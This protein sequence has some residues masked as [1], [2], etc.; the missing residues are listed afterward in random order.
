MEIHHHHHHLLCFSNIKLEMSPQSVLCMT[1][2][3]VLIVLQWGKTDWGPLCALLLIKPSCS[4]PSRFC[5]LPKHV[6]SPALMP[7]DG[8]PCFKGGGQVRGGP[9]VECHQSNQ[10]HHS[11]GDDFI[12]SADAVK[13]TD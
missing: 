12:S 8:T 7:C 10:R 11:G 4:S 6:R 9:A 1:T 13:I 3:P 5:Y 2:L